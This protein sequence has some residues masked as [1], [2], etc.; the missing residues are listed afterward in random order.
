MANSSWD[1]DFFAASFA[2]SLTCWTLLATRLTRWPSKSARLAA[3]LTA[4]VTFCASTFSPLLFGSGTPSTLRLRL[5]RALRT[6]APARPATTA[7]PAT[8]GTFAFWATVATPWA[9]FWAPVLTVSLAA[10]AAL[11]PSDADVERERLA[12][13]RLLRRAVEPFR[14][15]LLLREVLLPR[16]EAVLLRAFADLE[17]PLRLVLVLV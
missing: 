6:A 17:D 7:P 1:Y 11:R 5:E 15:V 9:A 14:D 2:V 4:L 10:C 3:S 12:G 13:A 8:S 16:A